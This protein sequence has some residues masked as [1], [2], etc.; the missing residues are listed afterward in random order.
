MR[1]IVSSLRQ[2]SL[3]LHRRRK[4][5]ATTQ[6]K[7]SRNEDP[8]PQSAP[9]TLLYDNL[10]KICL[11]ECKNL[12]SRRV[13]DEMPQRVA[14]AVKACK[15]I[16]LQSLKLGFAS[17]GHLGNSI[18]DLYAKCGDMVSAEKAFFWLENKDGMAW[19][20]IILMYSRNGLLENVVEAFGSMWNSGVWPNQF[21]YAIVL[22]ACARLVEVEIGKQVHCSV[23]KTGFEFDSFTEG[24]LIDM[25]AKCG[26]LIDARRI[27][28]GAVEPDNVSWTAMI[29]AYIQVGLPQKAMEVFEEMQE[30][31]CVPDQV[32]SVTIIN[33]C[34]GLGRLDAARQ[35][36]T[37]MTCPNV[38]AW[39]VMISGHAKGGK[40]V[41]A[42]QFFQDMI[43]ASI[44]PTRSTL[45]SVL[46][47]TA[48]VANLSF[49]LQVHAVAVKQG[50]ESNVYV[51]SS[52]INMYAKCQKMEAASE[53]FNS[54]GEK[55]EVLWNALLAGYAQNGSACK[56]VELF[57]SMRLSTFETDEYTYT[58]ILSAC[59]CLE[60]VEMGRQLHSIII[61]NK[62]A[63]NLFVGN[64]LIDMY[65][66][67]GALG[68][69]RQQFDKM[70][71][72]DHIS[73]NAIIV[74]YVQDEEEEE[75]FNMFHKMTLERII[76][77]EACL[78]SVLSACANI[79]D[80][81]KGKQVHSLLVKYGLESGLF[82]GSSLVDM[83]CKCGDITSASEV[84]FCL[85]DRSVVSTNALISGYAQKNINY[86]VHLFHNMLVEGLRPSEVTF[87]SILDAC[88]DHAYMLGRQLHSFILKLGFSYND[89]FLAISLIGM[90]YDSGKLEDASFLFSEFTKLNSPVLW[91]AMIS[92]NIQNDCCEEALIGYQE[93]RKFN[94]MPDQATFASA[95]K[96]CSTLAF[97]QDGRKIHCLIFHTGFD[98]DELTSSSLIDMYAKCG[99]VKCSV[100]V[101][102]EMVSKKDIIS[103]NSMI[104]GFA[105][106]GFAEDALEVFEEMKRASVKPDDITFL[107]VLTACS[108][109]GMVSEGRQIFKDMTSLYDVRPR[110]DH[111]ACMVDLLGR[112]GNLKEAEEFIERFDFEL[113]AMIWSAYL[114]ACKLHGDDTRGQKAAEK[115]IE[116]EPQNSSSY[117]L[118]SNIYAASGNWGGVNF[119]RKEMKERGVRKPPGCSWIIVGQKTNMFVAG[120]KF[121][122]CAGDIHALLKDLTALMKDEGYFADIDL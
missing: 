91:T 94:V 53:I 40:E 67:C 58:S 85:P 47:A 23:V 60:D 79:H 42:I 57:R 51:G 68:D 113:D 22:S 90:Y 41:E 76:P 111:C 28:D 10:L 65:A 92:G 103:W 64:A 69:A 119:L 101:F 72:R 115:L 105:K 83:Y 31:G 17:Q 104:V 82:A 93:M 71:T 19:N 107:G 36:F 118:L 6:A 108:H 98:M 29:S 39:N 7:Q 62:F 97:M 49:G 73:W 26:Y 54:L 20:S 30:R 84:F 50:L 44:R 81:N 16:H 117:I 5:S 120:D 121:H 2:Y 116:L 89:E 55:N 24:S 106:N 75:A 4:F 34:V 66:K 14:R 99:D 11:Q 100:Q 102:S 112:W 43:K 33:A 52:L 15:T 95:L 114:G 61:K 37:Q 27:F 32:A 12:Q 87:A 48:S 59:A 122:P 109:A 78:A 86:A 38:V 110:A 45:G 25:Y 18:V 46:S 8:E 35:L 1:H 96:A 70:L 56:V 13:F 77:D 63:S 3:L 74:G 88:S 80:L 21:S 9:V